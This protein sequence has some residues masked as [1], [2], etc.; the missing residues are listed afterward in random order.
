MKT[1][2]VCCVFTHF[3]SIGLSRYYSKDGVVTRKLSVIFFFFF[4]LTCLRSATSH[5]LFLE[6][7]KGNDFALKGNDFLPLTC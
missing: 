7:L 4:Y 1:K 6:I 3:F 2:G 5:R